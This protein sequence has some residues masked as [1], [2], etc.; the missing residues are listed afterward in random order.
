LN[1]P[2]ASFKVAPITQWYNNFY[3]LIFGIGG[4]VNMFFYASF[5]CYFIS[6]ITLLCI[7]IFFL[8]I[9]GIRK[10]IKIIFFLSIIGIASSFIIG[11]DAGAEKHARFFLNI[12]YIQ[13][14][15][16]FAC[17]IFNR[18]K[19]F[20]LALIKLFLS[21]LYSHTQP[22]QKLLPWSSKEILRVLEKNNLN[23]GF[24]PYWGAQGLA[25]SWISGFNTIIRPVTFDKLTGHMIISGRA[26]T[27]NFWYIQPAKHKTFIILMTD[28]EECHNLDMCLDGVRNQYGEP[29]EVINDSKM[30]IYV[31]ENGLKN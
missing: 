16:L 14:I 31:Y 28:V 24:G 6:S 11:T 18:N 9:E 20:Y 25:V 2:I 1:I 5:L 30:T 29:D 4:M 3:W 26:Q 7:L 22:E 10:D 12:V 15:V 19:L 23:Y 8:S 17:L 21:Q 13:L 27:F